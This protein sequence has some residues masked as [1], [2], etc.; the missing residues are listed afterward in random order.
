[1][2]R[3][4]ERLQGAAERGSGGGK[5]LGDAY[6]ERGQ[7]QIGGTLGLR[8][9]RYRAHDIQHVLLTVDAARE[10]CGAQALEAGIAIRTGRRLTASW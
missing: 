10:H 6:G 8:R 7:Q 9:G 3:V 4:H 1:L 5:A 2:I